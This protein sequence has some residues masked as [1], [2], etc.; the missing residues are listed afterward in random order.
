M[1]K[2]S[3]MPLHLS[4]QFSMCLV[5]L[6]EPTLTLTMSVSVSR[7]LSLASENK[8]N[9]TFW[10][11]FSFSPVQLSG[12]VGRGLSSPLLSSPLSDKQKQDQRESELFRC[13]EWIILVTWWGVW[14]EVREEG[15]CQYSNCCLSTITLIHQLPPSPHCPHCHH[16]I[17]WSRQQSV[18]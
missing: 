13:I 16:V 15:P 4:Q 5:Q 17:P 14:G 8:S 9:Y 10:E 7:L 1:E 6:E 18:S 2:D 12:C 11:N 3:H